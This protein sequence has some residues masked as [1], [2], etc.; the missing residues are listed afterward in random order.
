MSSDRDFV[1]IRVWDNPVQMVFV[2]NGFHFV[3]GVCDVMQ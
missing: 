2:E 3:T 1:R